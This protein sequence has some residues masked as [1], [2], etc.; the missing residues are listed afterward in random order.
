MITI[1]IQINPPFRSEIESQRLMAVVQ[2]VFS[3]CDVADEAELTFVLTSNETV[4]DL[5]R[6]YRGV[7]APTDV[8]SFEAFSQDATFFVE[9][10]SVP[11]LGDVM[12][13]VP[14]AVEQAAAAGHA[15]E[16]EILLLAIHGTLHLL[17]YDHGTD[18]EKSEMWRQQARILEINGLDHVKPSEGEH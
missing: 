6:R 11:Y 12:I 3:A 13:A 5:N 10:D 17:G 4:Q 9:Q 8:L 16:E 18:R 1:N 14:T 15:T 2:S 7:D